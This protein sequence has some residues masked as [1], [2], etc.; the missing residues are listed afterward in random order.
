MPAPHYLGVW[1]TLW[2]YLVLPCTSLDSYS[3]AETFYPDKSPT[4]FTLT[5]RY[6][7]VSGK[8][9]LSAKISGGTGQPA[10]PVLCLGDVDSILLTGFRFPCCRRIR[11]RIDGLFRTTIAHSDTHSGAG[12]WHSHRRSARCAFFCPGQPVRNPPR[13]RPM[14]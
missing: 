4:V 8:S 13:R 10:S 9:G 2:Y 6:Q 12:S 7:P 5:F 3:L 14:Q 11:S 1:D